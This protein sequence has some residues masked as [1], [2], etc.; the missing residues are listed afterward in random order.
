MTLISAFCPY[1]KYQNWLLNISHLVDM[2]TNTQDPVKATTTTKTSQNTSNPSQNI[3]QSF[4]EEEE[5]AI[6]SKEILGVRLSNLDM[7]NSIKVRVFFKKNIE[8]KHLCH[9]DKNYLLLLQIKY[10]CN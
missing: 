4:W 9:H 7:L 2:M 8:K 6:L 10:F 5:R 3:K 1:P